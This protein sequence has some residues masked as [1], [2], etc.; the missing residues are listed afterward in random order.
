MRRSL[1]PHGNHNPQ[2]GGQFFMAPDSWHH[3]EGAYPR[4]RVFR[5]YVYDDF[6]RTLAAQRMSEVHGRVVT[7]EAY[8]PT[9]RTTTE[10]ETFPLKLA[11]GG[12]YLE[13]RIDTHA[14]PAEVTAKMQFAKGGPEYRFDFTFTEVTKDPADA[15]VARPA[16]RARRPAPAVTADATP[17]D[18]ASGRR[19]LEAPEAPET[20][21]DTTRLSMSELL[22]QIQKRSAQTGELVRR[23]DF[24][25]VWIPAFATKELVVALEPHLAH[26]SPPAQL[27]AASALRDVV[28]TAWQLDAIADAGDRP[29]IEEAYTALADA[30]ARALAGFDGGP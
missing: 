29:R 13:A 22:T 5:V 16:A 17:P 23:G 4:E 8:N 27:V 6:A 14:L 21:F 2:H 12:T 11:R 24:G 9:T 19:L 30:V 10:L 18:A 3:L 28:R 20:G 25:S 7:R 15:V 26:L 1:R